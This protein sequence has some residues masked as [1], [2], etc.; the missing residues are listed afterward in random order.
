MVKAD[1]KSTAK[2]TGGKKTPAKCKTAR[3]HRKSAA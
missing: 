2:K 1:A 3:Q